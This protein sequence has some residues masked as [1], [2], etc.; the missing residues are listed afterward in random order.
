MNI[1]WHKFQIL[2]FLL[3]L[4]GITCAFWDATRSKR[5][6]DDQ[7]VPQY[8]ALDDTE[9]PTQQNKQIFFQD[10]GSELRSIDDFKVTSLLLASDI[11]GNL[12]ALNRNTGELVWTLLGQSP[13]VQISKQEV[14]SETVL[15]SDGDENGSYPVNEEGKITWMIEPYE[16]GSLYYFTQEG[17]LQ[18]LSSSVQNLIK[19]SPFA[20][21]GGE[22]VY[23]GSRKTSLYKIDA[24]TGRLIDSFGP[25]CAN[26]QNA[27]NHDLTGIED[28]DEAVYS[29]PI[30][31]Q[32]EAGTSTIL[33]GKTTYDLTIYSKNN[34]SWNI[35]YSA[36]GPNN[37]DSDLV[38]QN[39]ESLDG[40]YIAP[41]HDSSLLAIDSTSKVAKWV[42]NLPAIAVN[43]FDIFWDPSDADTD[44]GSLD[45]HFLVLPHPLHPNMGN[46]E[47]EVARLTE[48]TFV[49]RTKNGSW[50]AMSEYR[51]PS[52]VKSAP[53]AKYASSERWR[54]SSI[55]KS[56]D[57][58]SIAI[59]G[60]H[61]RCGPYSESENSD[62]KQLP[63]GLPKSLQSYERGL[64]VPAT[65][66]KNDHHLATRF[67]QTLPT[68]DVLSIDP[69]Q[70]DSSLESGILSGSVT[71]VLLRLFENIVAS[72][73]LL[74][75]LVLLSKL[76]VLP[77][78]TQ[79]LSRF[80]LFKRT[81]SAVELVDMLLKDDVVE[82]E[83]SFNLIKR[84]RFGESPGTNG[85]DDEDIDISTI[86]EE[87]KLLQ[88]QSDD[89]ET[90]PHE[91]KKNV[92]IVEP[93]SGGD[94]EE[95]DDSALVNAPKKRKRGA[96]GGKRNK[97]TQ[98]VTDEQSVS[99]S[100]GLNTDN[101]ISVIPSS[102]PNKSNLVIS[103]VVLGYGSH[104][105]VVFKGSFENRPV[106]VK[107]MLI[108]FYDVAS[109]EINLLQESDDHPN[110][111]RYFCSQESDRF[112]YIALE[113]CGAT[114]EDL[115]EKPQL[116]EGIKG[117]LDPVQILYQIANGLYHLHSLKIVHRDI[118][119][120]NILVVPPK[121]KHAKKI[122]AVENESIV[123]EYSPIRLLIS[124]F[125]L[126]KKLEA[127]QSSFRATTAQAAGTAGWRAPELLVDDNDSIYNPSLA[128]SSAGMAI[129][130]QSSEPLVFDSFSNRR[131]TR[132]IDVF[133]AGCIFYYV[134]TGGAH[135]FGDRY[136]REGNI[137]KGEYCLDLLDGNIDAVESKNLI[138]RMISRDCTKRPD[139]GTILKHPFFWPVAKK[140]DFLLKVSDRFEIERRDPP[141]DLLLSLEAVALDV[142]GK[143]GWH[144]KFDQIFLEN[145]GKYRKY[146]TDKL[147]D[148][149][150]A[151]RNKYHH[152]N[153]LPEALEKEMGPL[154]GGF[155]NYFATRFPN[156]LMAIYGVLQENLTHEDVFRQFF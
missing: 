78:L 62:V 5:S 97:K 115:I 35:T 51:Y 153:D 123:D 49:D 151:L 120:Q 118:K 18:K 112:L 147:M 76:G 8:D 96:R 84:E 86:I 80:G 19:E 31:E 46:A 102:I 131:F 26:E 91:K 70:N 155:Y 34:T 111:V 9:T 69:P 99:P 44:F 25:G 27:H 74:G 32:V 14:A 81:Q 141:S 17:G 156:M 121:K 63:T 66:E 1:R 79:I 98:A 68:P 58:M 94:K 132:S 36:W 71:K 101:A 88:K 72:L 54:S 146:N 13:L 105:T 125:G 149:L 107:R 6:N 4:T 82:L 108:D 136:L 154:P 143:E 119:P 12:H 110:V 22:H 23:T 142:V 106:A 40:V 29:C 130:S 114:L 93:D 73:V 138:S 75:T 139:T 117:K 148:L 11:E 135:P 16:D 42:S 89:H 7:V 30:D 33:L 152:F 56:E 28:L 57:M 48:G 129:S 103:D 24:R 124:D 128:S 140:L 53:I 47:E 126:C 122:T 60:V 85:D 104:G 150:R 37:L 10:Y 92:T 144:S 67:S 55:F 83:K 133:S 145:L 39:Y 113:L 52:L 87:K 50:F 59:A 20:M 95:G 100:E 134:L 21:N 109:H 41:F 127:D 38:R 77:P 43:V 15:G 90:T 64:Y 45:S 137:I 65:R 3:C 2:T 61:P 116:F